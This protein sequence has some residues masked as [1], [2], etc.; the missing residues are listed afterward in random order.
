MGLDVTSVALEDFEKYIREHHDN[1]AKYLPGPEMNN[2][3]D[4][5]YA[6]DLEMERRLALMKEVWGAYTI[7]LHLPRGGLALPLSFPVHK[8]RCPK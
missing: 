6:G 5:V 7:Y 8:S 1:C 2:A 3:W 4:E